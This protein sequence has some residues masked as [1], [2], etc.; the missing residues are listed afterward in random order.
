MAPAQTQGEIP[1]GIIR[2]VHTATRQ[3]GLSAQ[4]GF[5]DIHRIVRIL[6]P[7]QGGRIKELPTSAAAI[8]RFTNSSGHV[9]D[10][11]HV[12]ADNRGSCSIRSIFD[13]PTAR[14]RT[15]LCSAGYETHHKI[16]ETSRQNIWW[17]RRRLVCPRQ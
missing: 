6:T 9:C 3:T 17:T 10:D 7:P 13:N 11:S 1:L 4:T 5:I 14:L 16:T 8:A 2:R 12:F 15:V